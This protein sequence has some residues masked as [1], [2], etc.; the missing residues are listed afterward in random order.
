MKNAMILKP[1]Q[2]CTLIPL[3]A[4]C[5]LQ[6]FNFNL[7]IADAGRLKS[8]LGAFIFGHSTLI[9]VLQKGIAS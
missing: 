5:I 8:D 4:H 3:L 2:Y 1:D 7:E 6:A 9:R